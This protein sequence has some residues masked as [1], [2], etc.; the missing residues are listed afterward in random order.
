MHYYNRGNRGCIIT[1]GGTGDKY[2]NRGNRGCII[3][4]GGTGDALLQGEHGDASSQPNFIAIIQRV[5]RL[6]EAHN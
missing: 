2:Y 3:T 1:T 4:T 6:I 5:V